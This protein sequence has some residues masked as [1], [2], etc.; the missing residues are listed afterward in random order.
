M[1]AGC[2]DRSAIVPV[3]FG[4]SKDRALMKKIVLS[5]IL[6]LLPFALLQGAKAAPVVQISIDGPIGPGVASFVTGAIEDA[7]GRDVGA[8]LLRLDTP[9]GLDSSMREIIQ[10]ILDS[11]KPVVCFV[12]PSG[13]RAAS[14]GTY[15][16]MACHVAAMAEGTTIGAATPV[17]IGGGSPPQDDQKDPAK[18][19]PG[20]SE[21]ILNDSAAYM[22]G[23]A[24]MRGR[25]VDWAERFVREAVSVSDAEALK[26]GVI[27]YQ[28][29]SVR[30]LLTA[31][32][33][34]EVKVKERLLTLNTAQSEV[35]RAE[36][37]WRDDFLAAIS[38][39]NIAY[40][41]LLIGIYG[42]VFEFSNPGF[43]LPGIVGATSLILAM[44][45]LQLL[46]VNYAGLALLLLGLGLITAEAF[47]PSF[48]I[49]GIGGIVTFVFGSIMLFDTDIPGF[50]VSRN[51]I[52]GLAAFSSMLALFFIT[53]AVRAWRRPAISGGEGMIGAPG[54][55]LDWRGSAGRIRTHGEVW[56]ATSR[57]KLHK[58]AEV[59]VTARDGLT[60]EVEPQPSEGEQNE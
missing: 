41:L 22:R 35:I 38:D 55:V 51:L 59:R 50:Q 23:L 44:Y 4:V 28:A 45:A 16:L 31:I 19:K 14:A 36:P 18:G 49:L 1:H 10:Q 58:G 47:L 52:G 7:Q 34:R 25:P 48:G 37:S 30:A 27:D 9:G 15:I 21:K 8:I 5:L 12:S 54:V 6:S 46:P 57:G 39:P 43:I 26:H 42:L 40:I 56:T 13:A 53:F 33:G 29:D 24:E 11:S 20:M 3:A 60:L 32:D 17:A 2:I